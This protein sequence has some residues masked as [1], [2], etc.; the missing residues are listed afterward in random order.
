MWE[1]FLFLR[2]NTK[3]KTKK[4]LGECIGCR[5]KGHGGG[6]KFSQGAVWVIESLWRFLLPNAVGVC[7][8]RKGAKVSDNKTISTKE[9]CFG[10]LTNQQPAKSNIL[11]MLIPFVS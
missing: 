4:W 11:L 8:N 9:I 5:R 2:Q 10:L 7:F 3:V 1:T 6:A